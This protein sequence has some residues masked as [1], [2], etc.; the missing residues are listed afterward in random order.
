MRVEAVSGVV[1]SGM[2]IRPTRHSPDTLSLFEFA[3]TYDLNPA[4]KTLHETEEI[5]YTTYQQ[6]VTQRPGLG[7]D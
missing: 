7:M 6:A 3:L 4:P 1:A 2:Q 5:H